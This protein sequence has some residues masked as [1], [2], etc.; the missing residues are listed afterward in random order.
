MRT[1]AALLLA[2][3][4]T[5]SAWLTKLQL[6]SDTPAKASQGREVIQRNVAVRMRDGVTLRADVILPTTQGRFPVL[7]YRTPY[8]KDR[9]P[10]SWTTFPKAVARGY[11]VVIQDVRGRYESEGD[12]TPYRTEGR[13]GYDTIEWA[14]AQPWSNGSV[15]TF[16]LSYPGAVQWLAAVENPPHLKAMVPA[17]TF[18][19]PQ[20]FFYAGGTWDM[21]WIEWI[22][23]NIA[24]D[25][26]VKKNLAGPRTYDEEIVTWQTQ[27]PKMLSI[28]PL[29]AVEVL[30]PVAPFYYEWLAHPPADPW[31][32]W[33]ELQSK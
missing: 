19:T 27:G 3:G 28:L 25:V 15:G 29:N 10:S 14:A 22:W 9:A 13:D 33:A 12:F 31:W 30:R 21:S 1:L 26:R 24:P 8:G 20:N 6:A 32:D 7:V 2:A 23:D 4:A 5:F 16:G 11:A 17:M 18:S